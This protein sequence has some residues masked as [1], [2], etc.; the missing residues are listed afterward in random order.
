MIGTVCIAA[1]VLGLCARVR[2]SLERNRLFRRD[3]AG[4]RV[5]IAPLYNQGAGFEALPLSARQMAPLSLA[6]LWALLG[7]CGGRG[8]GAGLL[9]GG[10]LSNLWERIRHGRVLDYLRFPKAPGP[11]KKYTYNLADLAIF[12]GAV[13]MVLRRRRQ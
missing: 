6:A 7:V 10:G 1:A 2:R 8:L 9:L 12:L 11:L 13:L 3:L 5:R 4:G